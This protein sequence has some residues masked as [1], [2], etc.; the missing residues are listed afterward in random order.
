MADHLPRR[1]Y[2]CKVCGGSG[3]DSD[4]RLCRRCGG[5]GCTLQVVPP[6]PTKRGLDKLAKEIRK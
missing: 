4:G 5:D 3:Y 1:H 6:K 2:K